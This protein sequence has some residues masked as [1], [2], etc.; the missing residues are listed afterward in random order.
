MDK[1]HCQHNIFYILSVY[2]F[3]GW[4]V[5]GNAKIYCGLAVLILGSEFVLF[6]TVCL[7]W[8]LCISILRFSSSCRALFWSHEVFKV[9]LDVVPWNVHVPWENSNSKSSFWLVMNLYRFS[10]DLSLIFVYLSSSPVII[11]YVF[12]YTC[13]KRFICISFHQFGCEV[14][15]TFL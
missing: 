8:S 6:F 10:L 12:W 4:F 13:D 7:S 9:T 15:C 3:S 2:W 5:F 11:W 1:V 14:A